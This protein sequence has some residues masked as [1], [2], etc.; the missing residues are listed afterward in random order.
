MAFESGQLA[1]NAI[2]LHLTELRR[3]SAFDCLAR[4]YQTSYRRK[5]DSRLRIS[6]LLRRAAYLPQ[7]AEA[8]IAFFGASDRLRKIAARATRT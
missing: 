3:G 8:A 4:T 7:T 2:L 6:G 1:A 5:F